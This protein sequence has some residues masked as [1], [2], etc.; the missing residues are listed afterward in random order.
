M[1]RSL[2]FMLICGVLAFVPAAV[3]A[4]DDKP[5]GDDPK[6]VKGDDPKKAEE[7]KPTTAEVK[8]TTAAKNEPAAPPREL[9]IFEKMH[10][11]GS[12]A[13]AGVVAPMAGIFILAI[14]EI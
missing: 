3:L 9:T 2:A 6:A 1:Y 7:P 8:A 10:W 4:Q 12:D 5:K 14:I 11:T 13:I